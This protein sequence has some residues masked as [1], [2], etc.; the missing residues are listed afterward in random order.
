MVLRDLGQPL[1][2]L[3]SERTWI[4]VTRDDNENDF[5]NRSS[6]WCTLF[7]ISNGGIQINN[8][9]VNELEQVTETQV[10]QFIHN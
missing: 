7:R 3:I 10:A 2:K 4:P 5:R 6:I 1:A 8:S 9:G